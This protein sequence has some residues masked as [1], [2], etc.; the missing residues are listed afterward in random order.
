MSVRVNLDHP[1]ARDLSFCYLPGYPKPLYFT[2]GNFDACVYQSGT[3]QS[4]SPI[5]VGLKSPSATSGW[6]ANNASNT[7]SMPQS[8][9]TMAGFFFPY[10]TAGDGSLRNLFQ[11][12]GGGYGNDFSVIIWNDGNWYA[13]WAAGGFDRRVAAPYAGTVTAGIP[14]SAVTTWSSSGTRFYAGG[15]LVAT[16]GTGPA[17]V[18][19]SGNFWIG[20][21]PPDGSNLGFSST[22]NTTINLICIWDR[23]LT[24]TEIQLF[25]RDPFCFLMPDLPPLFP[26]YSVAA[27]AATST[28]FL[29]MF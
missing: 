24:A 19:T 17:T 12:G 21:D 6:G 22:D 16:N 27:Q 28:N 15:L 5:G 7:Y 11:T 8:S 25:N 23:E 2:R 13:G 26:A 14:T 18:V 4:L 9:G 29:V 20:A 10:F 1:L 3:A